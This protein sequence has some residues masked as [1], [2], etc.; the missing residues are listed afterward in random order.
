MQHRPTH[1]Q[2][3]STRGRTPLWAAASGALFLAW[4]NIAA[5]IPS[6]YVSRFGSL[7]IQNS[8]NSTLLRD[9][10]KSQTVWVL[11]PTAGR[12][13]F[14]GLYRSA[15]LTFC[16]SIKNLATA[17]GEINLR[18]ANLYKRREDLQPEMEAAEKALRHAQ[19]RLGQVAASQ[20][21]TEVILVQ[22][23]VDSLEK[24]REKLVTDLNTC[25]QACAQVLE[26]FHRV[27][28]DLRATKDRLTL[29]QDANRD[30]VRQYNLAKAGVEQARESFDTVGE[31]VNRLQASLTE[32]SSQVFAMY[33]TMGKLEGG[34]AQIDYSTG[35]TE[36]VGK[37]SSE[38]P[39][40][41]FNQIPTAN[42]RIYANI[43]GAS[44]EENYYSSLPAILDYTI[45]GMKYVPWGD[46]DYT[47]AALPS[48][49]TGNVRL[50]TLGACPIADSTFFQ[51]T[52]MTAVA[53]DAGTPLF[54]I[55]ASY[56][57][58]V[59]FKYK[60]TASYNLYKFYE[61]IKRSGTSG[62]LF[63][64]SSYS[65]VLENKI[66]RDAFSIDWLIEDPNSDMDS[67]KRAEITNELKKDL[68]NRVLVTIAQPGIP[69]SS[70]PTFIDA[71][72]PP[73]PGA[74][75]FADGLSDTCGWNIYCQ[76]GSWILRGLTAIFGSSSSEQTF[77]SN[78]DRTA[79]ETWS[80]ETATFRPGITAFKR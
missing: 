21:M 1:S 10:E 20:G 38:F 64:S 79:T 29:L 44:S 36:N 32:L 57:Y 70:S 62:G 75:V 50:S 2:I 61:Q 45:N 34:N 58:P 16:P 48:V 31:R 59:A 56:E 76:A 17:T 15:N 28:D 65:E 30:E 24:K 42:A 80:A 41:S 19:E 14:K 5:A 8:T 3:P 72:T 23:Q 74:I 40:F 6:A 71:G 67:K 66:D 39:Q 13:E 7:P 77:R 51:G 27:G 49:L 55:S 33:G 9:A 60:V 69:Q 53:G 35:W 54:S 18:I 47:Q 22:D 78:W 25:T 37:L 68:M 63:S 52:G 46:S 12:T 4:S 11:P 26:E 73:T 43:I